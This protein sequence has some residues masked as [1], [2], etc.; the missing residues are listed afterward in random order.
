MLKEK[1]KSLVDEQNHMD[2]LNSVD[3]LGCQWPHVIVLLNFATCLP[4]A[5]NITDALTRATISL[6]VIVNTIL[7][8][9]TINGFD[10]IQTDSCRNSIPS[11][12]EKLASIS[13]QFC[14]LSPGQKVLMWDHR[15]LIP[16]EVRRQLGRKAFDFGW[17]KEEGIRGD[18]EKTRKR[19]RDEAVYVAV[20]LPNASTVSSMNSFVPYIQLKVREEEEL[21]EWRCTKSDFDE[22]RINDFFRGKAASTL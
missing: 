21:E 1:V 20:M 2:I 6:T 19:T 16:D 9:F 15:D 4:I 3:A 22:E 11:L 14:R 5:R 12:L 13:T 17:W 18:A 10:C 7:T 8:P